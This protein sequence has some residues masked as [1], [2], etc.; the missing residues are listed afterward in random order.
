MTYEVID[1]YLPDADFTRIQRTL[2]GP[3]FPWYLNNNI[4]RP[5]DPFHK[6]DFQLVHALYNQPAQASPFLQVLDPLI[7]AINPKALIRIK[8]NLGPITAEH[9]ETGYHNDYPF[10]CK[11]A[12]FYINTNNGY[13]KFETGEV[14]ES[15]ANRL[16]IFDSNM[17]HT[18]AT[19]TDEKVR[20]VLNLNFFD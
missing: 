5:T 1:N 3:D 2:M 11:T 14:V 7:G 18:G 4:I 17:R 15:V 13:T 12:C 20:V 19:Q 8:A 9:Y 6:N 16:M 10:P